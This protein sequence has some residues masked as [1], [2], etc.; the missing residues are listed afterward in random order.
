[1]A[2]LTFATPD[3]TPDDAEAA[4]PVSPLSHLAPS[5]YFSLSPKTPWCSP[6]LPATTKP[7]IRTHHVVRWDA[8]LDDEEAEL[9]IPRTSARCG[10]RAVVFDTIMAGGVMFASFLSADEAATWL[11]ELLPPP[12]PPCS[13]VARV[14][15]VA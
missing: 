4:W 1:M 8:P 13:R 14:A 6:P 11:A 10:D 5:S 15:R 2:S 7:W 9:I 3:P 12:P